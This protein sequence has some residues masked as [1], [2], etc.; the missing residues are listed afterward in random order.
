MPTFSAKRIAY[1]LVALAPFLSPVS[2]HTWVEE[3]DIIAPNGTFVGQPGYPRGYVPR[4]APGFSDTSMVHLLPPN[5]RADGAKILPTDPI[6][7]DSQ[8]ALTQIPNFPRLKAQPGSSIALRYQENGHV[9]LP[10]NQKGKADNRGTVYVYGTTQPKSDDTLLAVHNVWN[11]NGTGGDK[12]GVLLATQNYDDGQCYQVN[13]GKIST[14]RQA[15]FKHTAD[16][17][18]GADLWCQTD[19]TIPLD[20]PSGKPYTTYWVWDWSTLPNIDPTLPNG[21]PEFYTSCQDVD[22]DAAPTTE[23]KVQANASGGYVQGQNLNSAA[24]PSFVQGLNSGSTMVVPPAQAAPSPTPAA[25]SPPASSASAVPAPAASLSTPA[26]APAPAYSAPAAAPSSA[27]DTSCTHSMTASQAPAQSPPSTVTVTVT[28]SASSTTVPFQPPVSAS[29]ESAVSAHST[30]TTTVTPT[31][32]V[33]KPAASPSA[34]PGPESSP[35]MASVS[36]VPAA[37]AG[38]PTTT[39][40][41]TVSSTPTTLPTSTAAAQASGTAAKVAPRCQNCGHKASKLLAR[42]AKFRA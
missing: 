35:P 30:S 42:S 15:K 6:C 1:A 8:Q 13:G 10:D 20:A 26:E 38:Q 16:Q 17:L 27:S 31:I 2:A 7:K 14:D 29:A 32:Y 33:T 22:V 40:L 23:K 3:I 39:I 5:G 25:A 36:S 28:V 4:S 34:A 37:A 11:Q 21:K 19:F 41:T 24:L 18:M 12:R 9:T